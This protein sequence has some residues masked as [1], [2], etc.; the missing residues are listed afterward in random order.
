MEGSG[1]IVVASVWWWGYVG[2][3]SD[4]LD[5]WMIG[6]SKKSTGEDADYITTSRLPIRPQNAIASSTSMVEI[7]HMTECKAKQYDNTIQYGTR[8]TRDATQARR[9]MCDVVGP[10][11]WDTAQP[12]WSERDSA[13]LA[14]PL[15]TTSSKHWGLLLQKQ[16]CSECWMGLLYS[17]GLSSVDG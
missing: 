3:L 1:G 6:R 11:N 13:G 5:D 9:S 8:V 17:T 10:R 7:P 2:E 14:V 4:G 12:R 15:S 16:I